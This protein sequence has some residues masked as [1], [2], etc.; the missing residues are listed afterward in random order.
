MFGKSVNGDDANAAFLKVFRLLW[1]WPLIEL[2]LFFVF[3]LFER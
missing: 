2:E 1:R 3:L